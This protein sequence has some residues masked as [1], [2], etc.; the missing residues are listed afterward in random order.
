MPKVKLV[1]YT[2]EW[3]DYHSEIRRMAYELPWQEATQREVDL[4]VKNA[5]DI[6]CNP[7]DGVVVLVEGK[8]DLKQTIAEVVAVVEAREQQRK[9]AAQRRAEAAQK[10]AEKR[11]EKE[12]AKKLAML[13]RLKKEVG[14]DAR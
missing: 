7:Y 11:A 6:P 1:F 13:Q 10:R 4:L 2:K 12:R 9:M 8:Q 5:S 3:D 14:D